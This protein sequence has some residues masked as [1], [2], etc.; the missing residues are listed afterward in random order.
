MTD[1]SVKKQKN[2]HFIFEAI[3]SE[4]KLFCSPILKTTK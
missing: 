1:F 3:Q 2:E 4:R